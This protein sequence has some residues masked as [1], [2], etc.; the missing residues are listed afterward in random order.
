M[1]NYRADDIFN[2]PHYLT[3]NHAIFLYYK[4]LMI[5]KLSRSLNKYDESKDMRYSEADTTTG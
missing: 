1:V 5:I 2:P 4:M 3:D